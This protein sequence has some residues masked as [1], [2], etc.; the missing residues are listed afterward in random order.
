MGTLLEEFTALTGELNRLGIDYAVCG[1]WAM[2]IH[3]LPRATV[4]IDLMV[5][6][7]DLEKAWKVAEQ[8]GYDVEGLPLHFDE[9]EIRR[10]SK[11]DRETKNLLTVDFLL[12]T[13]ALETIWAERELIEWELG[14]I[15]TVSRK[16]LIQLKAL[17]GRPQD[18]IDIE[19]LSEDSDE[20]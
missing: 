5:R 10:I 1:G 7:N 20:S 19:K 17:A 16:G 9:V 12:V 14:G 4:D 18:L 2:S 15:W 11:I 8:L 3:G 6:S 13:D